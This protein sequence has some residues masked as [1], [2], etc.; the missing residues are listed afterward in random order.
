MASSSVIAELRELVP[1]RAINPI[2]TAGLAER[3]ATRLLKLTGITEPPVPEFVIADLPR[4]RVERQA[5]MPFSGAT[6]WAKGYWLILLNADEP[7]VRRRFSLAHEFK[8][9]L[10]H[11]YIDRL[12]PDTPQLSSPDRAE[13]ACDLFAA[14]LLMPRV[15][16][17]R[18]WYGGTTPVAT[19]A[20]EFAVSQTAMRW[21]LEQ[22]GIAERTARHPRYF[23]T[24]A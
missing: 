13:Q 2:E 4:I 7:Y 18:A 21:R 17:K 9:I 6:H 12:Y 3:Q 11:P 8:H 23:R 16:V 20:R 14:C 10:D 22:L 1:H 5:P 15:W 24:A 19:L